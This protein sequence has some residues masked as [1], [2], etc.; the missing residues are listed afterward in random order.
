MKHLFIIFLVSFTALTVNAQRFSDFGVLFGG[1]YYNGEI[2]PTRQFYS[3]SLSYG[4]FIRLNLNKRFAIRTSGYYTHLKGNVNDFPDRV[5]HFIPTHTEAFTKQLLDLT[6]QLEFN[7]LPYITGE[8]NF[9][10][11]TYIAGGI[12][13]GIF[14]GSSNSL[15]IPFGIGAKMN[16]GERL[17]GGL[18]W[19]FRKTF[20]DDIDNNPNPLGNSL[21]NN[22]DWYSIFGLFI[23][24]KF[25]KFAADCPAYN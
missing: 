9:L 10:R 16:L 20:A 14:S 6:G 11:S 1:A 5:T 25:V 17:S 21:I 3:P 13:Y 24:Y 7:F 12:G 19:S 8:R 15:L 2:N 22:N 4:I 23:S 18:E